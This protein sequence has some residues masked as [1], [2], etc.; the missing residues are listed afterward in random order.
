LGDDSLARTKDPISR[1]SQVLR[2]LR[3]LHSE[4]LRCP[5]LADIAERN[6]VKLR[7]HPDEDEQIRI[8]YLRLRQAS[9]KPGNFMA[10]LVQSHLARE[11][12]CRHTCDLVPKVFLCP[13]HGFNHSTLLLISTSCPVVTFR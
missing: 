8:G 10:P 3:I 9:P 7:I 12:P 4:S 5:P 13:G 11:H 1:P 2:R 6:V